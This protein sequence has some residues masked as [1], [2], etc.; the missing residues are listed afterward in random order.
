MAPN[1]RSTSP[2]ATRIRPGRDRPADADSHRHRA[3]DAAL[4]DDEQHTDAEE[5]DGDSGLVEIEPSLR[6]QRERGLESRE[7][8]DRHEGNGDESPQQRGVDR[9]L[10]IARVGASSREWVSGNRKMATQPLTNAIA[11]A[12]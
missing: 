6:E 3:D 11:A 9:L 2:S 4:H 8:G 10:G 7:R 5:D 12:T 1:A